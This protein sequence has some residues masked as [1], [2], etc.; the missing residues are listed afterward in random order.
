MQSRLE[1]DLY[2]T[3]TLT[4]EAINLIAPNIGI[5][6]GTSL[7]LTTPLAATS[8]GTG[9]SV[10][11]V[12]DLLYASTTTALSTRNA[13]ATAG[14]Y[15]RNGGASTA[16]LWS[17]LILPNAA[18]ASYLVF[19][20]AA[21]TYGESSN[22]AYDAA[23]INLGI[24]TA[25][26]SSLNTKLTLRN[27]ADADGHI[28]I[29]SSG[30]TSQ[31]RCYIRWDYPLGTQ[32]WFLG[33]NQQNSLVW[34]DSD[35]ATHRIVAATAGASYI[36]S[37]GTGAIYMNGSPTGETVGTGGFIVQSGGATPANQFFIRS[38]E[39]DI[40]CYDLLRPLAGMLIQ[41]GTTTVYPL[42]FTSGTS[43]TTAVAGTME[44]TG[45]ELYFTI[46]TGAARKK[47]IFADAVGG[48]TA[49]RIPYCTTSTYNRLTDKLNLTYDGTTFQ[50]IGIGATTGI[51]FRTQTSGSVIGTC[52]NDNGWIGNRIDAPLALFHTNAS[53]DAQY[54][55][56]GSKPTWLLT[57]GST[58]V[59]S[60]FM[61]TSYEAVIANPYNGGSSG[62]LHFRTGSSATLD[63][64]T[65]DKAGL[66]G[67]NQPNPT[68]A[69]DVVGA[70]LFSTT[71][72]VTGAFGCNSK[73]AQTA[74]ASGGALAAY[75]TGAFGLDS[76]AHMTS[77]YNL[78]VA[79]RAAL[80]ANGIMS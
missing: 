76:D 45:D 62:G 79:M 8:G 33:I 56:D 44:F 78:V 73:T 49:G 28:L 12:G 21:N 41:A 37:A 35:G 59:F 16:P 34:Y 42:R 31:Q 64:I 68:V 17:T 30:A 63:R 36:C 65:I 10:F 29:M 27:A 24:G 11:A 5:A 46:T 47:V 19:A 53:P 71:L 50:I 23:N 14:M 26:Y 60:F 67:I 57:Y 75:T 32:K 2:V 55:N 61:G 69:L 3:G 6:T 15:L 66:V 40:L 51:A 18:T 20:S 39:R 48:L 7:T 74:Y 1:G 77:L 43:L 58:Q 80:V 72:T 9:Q 54:A 22:L 4:A 13:G 38:A 70:G 52:I 25:P